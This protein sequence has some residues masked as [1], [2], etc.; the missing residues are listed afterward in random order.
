MRKCSRL[1]YDQKREIIN[2]LIDN[3]SLSLRRVSEIFS[4]RFKKSISRRAINDLKLNKQKILGINP[5]YGRSS[6]FS[7]LRYSAIDSEIIAWIDYMES[8]GACLNDEIILSKATEIAALNGLFEFKA[9]K[10]WLEKFKKRHNV[11][12]R[13]FHGELGYTADEFKDQIEDFG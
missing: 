1:S 6:R 3:S 12:L 7:K 13:I 4:S 10:G 2:Y 11:K 9:S 8:I 5:I